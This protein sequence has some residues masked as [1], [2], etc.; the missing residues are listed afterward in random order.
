M[1]QFILVSIHPDDQLDRMPFL[2]PAQSG[3]LNNIAAKSGLTVWKDGIYTINAFDNLCVRAQRN[4]MLG[5][6]IENMELFCFINA[7]LKNGSEFIL[8]YGDEYNDLTL[9]SDAVM[10]VDS[11]VKM[12]TSCEGEIYLHY[13]KQ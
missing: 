7:I 13:K 8:W 11:I 2:L 10:A 5:S 1:S 6:S 3:F 12:L 4:L 9:Y